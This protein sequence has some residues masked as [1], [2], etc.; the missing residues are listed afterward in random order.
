MHAASSHV[1]SDNTRE[2]TDTAPL[3]SSKTVSRSSR[4]PTVVTGRPTLWAMQ[5][6]DAVKTSCSGRLEIHPYRRVACLSPHIQ[7]PL[8]PTLSSLSGP[9][10]VRSGD[11]KGV[12]GGTHGGYF[13]YILIKNVV[14]CIE[15]RYRVVVDAGVWLLYFKILMTRIEYSF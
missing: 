13:G 5:S 10:V 8:S 15:L 14:V 9:T 6:Q 7:R 2:G 12:G 1:K 3:R 11:S 4:L